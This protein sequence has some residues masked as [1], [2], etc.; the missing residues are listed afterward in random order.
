MI[1]SS[2]LRI[3]QPVDRLPERERLGWERYIVQGEHKRP[4]RPVY[5]QR[6]TGRSGRLG[7]LTTEEE[8][9]DVRFVDGRWYV[10][11]WRT[12]L[13]VLASLLSLRETIPV[14]VADALVPEAEARRA[15][16]ELARIRRRDPSA[17]PALLQSHWHVPVRWFVLFARDERRLA[18]RPEGSRYRLHYWT[19]LETART[20]A[21]R[22][23][24]VLQS[25]ELGSVAGLVQELDEWLSCFEG[26][27]A[28]ELDYG[29]VADLF[30]WNDLEEDHSAAEIQGALDALEIGDVER[31][32]EL[33]QSVAGRWAEAQLRESLN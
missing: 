9:A 2:F 15:A 17:V 16:R 24:R 12:R 21:R 31:A 19:T 30:G 7:L 6:R 23:M 13:R 3:F 32:G 22:A 11:P 28:V 29:G 5:R 1:A 20:R 25:G 14:E 26:G 18:E 33:Y 27:A 4:S 10:C 8:R